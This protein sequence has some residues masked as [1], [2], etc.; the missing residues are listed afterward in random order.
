VTDGTSIE[1]NARQ[2]SCSRCESTQFVVVQH[3]CAECGPTP[4]CPECTTTHLIEVELE[5]QGR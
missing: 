1:V 2:L 5:V 3:F 4:L